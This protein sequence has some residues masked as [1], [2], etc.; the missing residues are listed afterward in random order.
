MNSYYAVVR[1]TDHLAHYGVKGMQWGVR[2]ALHEGGARGERRLARQYKKAAKK[3]AK[4]NANADVEKQNAKANKLNKVAKIGAKVGTAGAGVALAGQGANHGLKYINSLHKQIATHKL[5]DI[6]NRFTKD[7]SDVIDMMTFYNGELHRGKISKAEHA[8]AMK[9]I[10]DYA[11]KVT[12]KFDDDTNTV[13]NDFNKGKDKR[14]LGADIG[15]YASYGGAGLAAL[16][17]GAAIG[18]KIAAHKAKKRTTAE[19]HAKAVSERDSW[20]REMNKAFKGTKYAGQYSVPA[21]TERRG[22]SKWK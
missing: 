9:D 12:Q 2:K 6:N 15:R 20:K 11:K 3:L 1:S 8:K 21:K 14:K 13:I 16:G 10:D 5:S 18:S 4:L 17:Y 19:G 7:S 22:N